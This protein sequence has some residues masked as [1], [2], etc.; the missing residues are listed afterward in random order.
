MEE[1]FSMREWMVAMRKNKVFHIYMTNKL[2]KMGRKYPIYEQGANSGPD[3]AHP[4][5]TK[6]DDDKE[7]IYK[8]PFL[9]LLK[10][11]G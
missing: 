5:A 9:G 10:E 11:E 4:E 6:E 1:F 8:P 2:R 3:N 7:I